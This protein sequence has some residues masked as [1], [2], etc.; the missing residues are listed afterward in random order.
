[1]PTPPTHGFYCTCIS[2]TTTASTVCYELCC[3]FL[4]TVSF[5][6][7]H[8]LLLLHMFIL[9]STPPNTASTF[10]PVLYIFIIV[11]FSGK[12]QM[13]VSDKFAG[14]TQMATILNLE[15]ISEILDSFVLT[16]MVVGVGSRHIAGSFIEVME[17]RGWRGLWAGNTVNMLHIVPT[18]T[19]KLGTFECVKKAVTSGKG[20]WEKNGLSFSFSWLSPTAVG[21]AA[22]GIVSTLA[23]H[24]LEVLKVITFTGQLILYSIILGLSKICKEGGI[25]TLYS[26]LSPTLIGMLPYSACY[27]F[28][29][30]KLQNNYWERQTKKSLSR[31]EMLL[32]GAM[33]GELFYS[34][35][36]QLPI[37]VARKRLMVGALQGKC[38]PNMAAAL[39]EVIQEGVKGLY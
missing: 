22:A 5:I 26:G 21:G 30:E 25:G 14:I 12:T 18:Q 27:Y 32:I 11:H 1:M 31:P 34:N 13:T 9:I 4:S 10:I 2:T 6:L 24:H 39:A 38:P 20:D 16:C 15:K 8:L 35:H 17:H 37:E 7:V 28:M 33:S 3:F 23:C 19:I 36:Y 29:Y